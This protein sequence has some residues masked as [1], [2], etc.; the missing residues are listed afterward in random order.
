MA[1]WKLTYLETG[2]SA[3]IKN[4]YSSIATAH[5]P[6]LFLTDWLFSWLSVVQLHTL[7]NPH[8]SFYHIC[9]FSFVY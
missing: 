4:L 1:Y 7:P 6:T 9:T 5:F 3:A 8:L 2:R